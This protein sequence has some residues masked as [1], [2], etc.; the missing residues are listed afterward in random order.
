MSASID[1]LSNP[2]I[3]AI[4]RL[5]ARLSGLPQAKVDA[6]REASELSTSDWAAMGPLPTRMYLA[7]L[8]SL[9]AANTLHVIHSEYGAATTAQRIVFMQAVSEARG[10]C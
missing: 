4:D 6:A 10:R 7:G 5:D 2:I 9:D 3:E 1:F 8:V